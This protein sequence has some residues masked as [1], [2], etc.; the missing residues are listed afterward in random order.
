M[1]PR[2]CVTISIFYS[3]FVAS[4]RTAPSRYLPRIQQ[5]GRSLLSNARL[6]QRRRR[7]FHRRCRITVNKPCR[8]PTWGDQRANSEQLMKMTMRLNGRELT[9][10]SCAHPG[11]RPRQRAVS[12]IVARTTSAWDKSISGRDNSSSGN[13]DTIEITLRRSLREAGPN[14]I[15]VGLYASH[16]CRYRLLLE[17]RRAL[18]PQTL[19]LPR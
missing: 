7:R 9:G 1:K 16:T 4:S 10:S 19:D 6:A 14:P 15:I 18:Q 5:R 11:L 3:S 8:S 12:D 17:K 2:S 13:D